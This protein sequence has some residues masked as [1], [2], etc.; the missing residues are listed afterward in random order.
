M[1]ELH[2]PWV[3]TSILLPLV[4]AIVVAMFRDV[5]QARRWALVFCGISLVLAT[6]EWID[7]WSLGT[8]EAHD[9]WD[10]I[11]WIFHEDI[12]LIDELNAP[13]LPLAALGTFLTILTTLRTKSQRFSYP[14]ALISQS[15]LIATLNC[16]ESW[17]LIVLLVVACVPPWLELKRRKRST[18]IFEVH[19]GLFMV[20]LVMGYSLLTWTRHEESV[21]LVAMALLAAAALLR[22]GI[23]PV[24]CWMTD[25]FEKASLGTALQFV[26]P[27]TGAYAVMRLVL[28]FAPDWTLHA[29]ALASLV[30][31]VYAAGMASVQVEARRFFCYLF[32]SNASL[33]LVGLELVTPI[34]LTGALCVWLSV[35]MSLTGFGITLR[36]IESRIGRISLADYHGL[37]EQMPSFAGFFLLTGLA[38]IGF[39]G[40]IGFIAVEL[41]VEGAVGVYPI[42]GLLVV[43]ASA[44]NGIAILSAYFQIFTGRPCHL[45]VPLQPKGSERFAI[46]I[47]SVLILAGGF[48]PQVGVASRYHAAVELGKHR[49]VKPSPVVPHHHAESPKGPKVEGATPEWLGMADR[50]EV[51]PPGFH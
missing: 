17:M 21:S 16:R 45:D 30:T 35:G 4:G 24:H 25:L 47:L 43:L 50:G 39:P 51:S 37:F 5:S 6:C 31:A 41:L 38:S 49:F 27:L 15:I 33:V 8:Y 34:G 40:T 46:L 29:I 44:F 10:V 18:R 48:F 1:P 19:M 28:P 20:L 7:F 22:S 12:F 2:F 32:L 42:V 3:E 23:I 9:H 36:C 13:L 11:E 14:W 26:T